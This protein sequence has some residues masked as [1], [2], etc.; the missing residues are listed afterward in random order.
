MNRLLNFAAIL[1]VAVTLHGCAGTPVPD[2]VG[3]R[4]DGSIPTPAPPPSSPNCVSSYV[5]ASEDPEHGIK[6]ISRDQFTSEEA[7]AVIRTIVEE[8]E[9]TEILAEVQGYIHAVQ[10]TAVWKFPD[11]VEFWFPADES[12]INFRSAARLGSS[13]LGVNRKRM[14]RLRDIYND[15]QP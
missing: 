12:V 1:I 5:D 13:D 2:E 15:Y 3:L 4:V 10:Y 9:R 7:Q 6:P 11:D 14:E 8:E